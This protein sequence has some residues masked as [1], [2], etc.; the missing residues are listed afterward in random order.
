MS[1]TKPKVFIQGPGGFAYATMFL[2]RGYMGARTLEDADIVCFT[3]GEDVNPDLYNEPAHHTTRFSTERDARDKHVFEKAYLCEKFCVGICRGA[4]FLNVMN[5]GRLWQDVDAHCR[6]HHVYD[7]EDAWSAHMC[8]STHHQ[9]MRP[10]ADGEI[11]GVCWDSSRRESGFRSWTR[12][13][14]A[15]ATGDDDVEVVWYKDTKS[16]CF[17][18]H[19]EMVGFTECTNWFFNLLERYNVP[20]QK[21]A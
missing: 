3:G 21:A 2:H 11:I 17:Q 12:D 20:E 19:P 7:T 6:P 5:G 16:L 13:D 9:M 8:S 4:Q 14:S 1:K 10:D 18:P 15:G